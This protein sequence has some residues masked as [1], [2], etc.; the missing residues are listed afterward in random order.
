M[1]N[2]IAQTIFEQIGGRKFLVMTGAEAIAHEDCLM[3]DRISINRKR[4]T[5]EIKYNA[6]TDSYDCRLFTVGRKAD[7]FVD[8]ITVKQVNDVYADELQHVFCNCTG[9]F[10]SL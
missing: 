10:T 9:L 3:L 4:H 1:K 2:Q 8:V 7:G 6:G 5:F